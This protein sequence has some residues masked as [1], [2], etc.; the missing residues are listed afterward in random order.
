MVSGR[1]DFYYE[2]DDDLLHHFFDQCS[3]E[4]CPVDFWGI[5]G[6]DWYICCDACR[7]A[8]VV[9]LP[10]DVCPYN[11]VYVE[12]NIWD[13]SDVGSSYQVWGQIDNGNNQELHIYLVDKRNPDYPW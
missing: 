6:P 4:E 5:L 9:C 10:D 2:N 8:G 3:K 1:N 12:K 11:Y 13:T 7:S